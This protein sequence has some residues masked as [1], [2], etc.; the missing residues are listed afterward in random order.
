MAILRRGPSGDCSTTAERERKPT[1]PAGLDARTLW[2]GD[3]G[4][5][6]RRRHHGRSWDRS[7]TVHMP[8]QFPVWV[9]APPDPPD[10]A[11]E[12][13]G[14]G[15][16]LAAFTAATPPMAMRPTARRSEAIVLREPAMT[17][18]RVDGG[19]AEVDGACGADSDPIG[20]GSVSCI[21]Y[22]S[23]RCGFERGAAGI[24]IGNSSGR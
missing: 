5:E 18:V 12:A 16:G 1:S 3:G 13:P 10:G 7:I 2:T 9:P 6:E 17:R 14:E 20:C 19:A 23:V 21:T 15:A 24:A 4:A 11:P 22:L 8:G